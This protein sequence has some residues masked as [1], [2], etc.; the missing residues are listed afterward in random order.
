MHL[1]VDGTPVSLD[2][3]STMQMNGRQM[4]TNDR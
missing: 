1:L 2:R 4:Q 3:Q